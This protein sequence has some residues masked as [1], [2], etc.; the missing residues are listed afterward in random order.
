MLQSTPFLLSMLYLSLLSSILAFL[1]LNFAATTLPVRKTT[2][3]C[4][5]TTVISVFAGAVFLGESVNF[6]SILAAALIIFSV[7]G[8][9]KT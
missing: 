6:V 3:F 1:C 7:I 5:M 4:N 2:A 8:V 9:Q